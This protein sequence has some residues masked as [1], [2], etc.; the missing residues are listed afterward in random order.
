MAAASVPARYTRSRKRH[1]ADAGHVLRQL[2][3]LGGPFRAFIRTQGFW[4]SQGFVY[5]KF[6]APPAA[7]AA[8]KA[9]HGRW[10]AGKQVLAEFQFAAAYTQRFGV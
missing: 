8:Q 5:V 6:E 10:F 2:I 7:Q 1:A 9:L 3:T 4:Y